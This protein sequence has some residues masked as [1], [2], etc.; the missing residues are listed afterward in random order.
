MEVI[1]LCSN[2]ETKYMES[3]YRDSLLLVI[4]LLR[5]SIQR[6]LTF[7]P[8]SSPSIHRYCS[9]RVS[10]DI[11]LPDIKTAKKGV[12]LVNPQIPKIHADGIMDKD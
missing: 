10:E 5:H 9:L 4:V 12:A 2:D 8:I 11:T 6:H 7:I 3:P 1:Q